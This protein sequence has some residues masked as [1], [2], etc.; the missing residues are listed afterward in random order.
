MLEKLPNL[1]PQKYN[2]PKKK[3]K[4]ERK[5]YKKRKLETIFKSKKR[6]RRN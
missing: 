6:N 3:S 4:K 2:Y 5:K 1:S